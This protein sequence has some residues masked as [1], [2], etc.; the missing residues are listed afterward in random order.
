MV[1]GENV[2]IYRIYLNNGE[3]V[4]IGGD[5]AVYNED[6][7]EIR[8]GFERNRKVVAVFNMHNIQGFST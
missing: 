5:G 7:L 6:L 4:E 3:I 1:Q 8:R 2:M